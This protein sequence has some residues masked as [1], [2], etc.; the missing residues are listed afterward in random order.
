MNI[1]Q[2]K[3]FLSVVRQGSIGAA[4]EAN[5][6]T[7][8]AVSLQIKKL[9]EE[10]GERLLV[11]RGRR[12]VLTQTGRLVA[13]HAEEILREM[14]A[15]EAAMHG[16]RGL[17]SGFLKLG[18]IDA[19]SVYVLP[20]LYR[21]FHHQYPGV[22]IEIVVGDSRHLLEAM[23]AGDLELA[24][25][26]LPVNRRGFQVLP[27]YQDE[28]VVVAHPAHELSRRKRVTINH[29]AEHGL[30]SYPAGSGTR[31]HIDGVFAE[32]G[33]DVR[34]TMEI[35]SPEAIKRLTQAGLGVSIL[36]RRMVTEEVSRKQLKVITTGRARFQRVI[37][38]IYGSESALSPAAR[39]FLGMAREHFKPAR[40][41]GRQ[42]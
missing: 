38:M 13:R 39:T 30:I 40:R 9:E 23:I 22:R 27:I 29:V 37:G 14:D 32:Q 15:L 31:A 18:N 3:Y 10:V 41:S 20:E 34:A 16:L 28:M 21:A 35:S 1:R 7:Q 2:L 19:A 33:V 4:A 25:V 42:S 17:T 24:T 12:S 26:T 8:P 5:F 11:R 36:P 6:V